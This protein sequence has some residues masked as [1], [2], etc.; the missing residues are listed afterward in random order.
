MKRNVP[1]R[2]IRFSMKNLSVKLPD[3]HIPVEKL[4]FNFARSSGPGGQN[5]NKLNTKAEM[6]FNVDDAD[7]IPDEVKARLKESQE[8]NINKMG[9]LYVS[10]QEHRTQKQNKLDCVEKLREMVAFAYLEPKERKMYEVTARLVSLHMNLIF[11]R[12]VFLNFEC[13]TS[14]LHYDLRRHKFL[15]SDRCIYIC[16]Q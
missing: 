12:F 14:Y 9:E 10:S 15:F 5:V 16:S 6:R 11:C 8:K 3:V 7:W 4:D 13:D 1:Y 2:S